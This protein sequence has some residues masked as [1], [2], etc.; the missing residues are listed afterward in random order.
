M[1]IGIIGQGFV[2]NAVYQKFKNFFKVYT[3]DIVA[4]LCNSSYD[5]LINNC[6]IIFICIP[7]PMNKDG[8]CNSELVKE[9]LF[10]LNKK[11]KAIVVN[12]ST[13]PPGTTAKFNDQFENLKIIFNPEFL[14]ERNAIEDFNNQDRIILG[15]PRPATTELKQIYSIVFPNAYVI[16]TGSTHAEMIKYFTNCFLA[17]KVSF[18]NEM[19]E[20]C[21]ALDLDYDKVVE[22]ATL[23]TRLGN[24]HW[25]VPGPDGDFGFGGHCFPKD[26]SAIIK[27]TND[28][29]TTNNILKSVQKTNNKVRNNRDWEK[30]KGRAVN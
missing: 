30:M 23:D 18:S 14:T 24:S 9:V 11:S 1:N 21:D 25:A 6:K 5:E 19:H 27:M 8:S 16:K 15:G 17:N 3:Y 12:K 13:I 29:G 28:L 22:Y 4:K 7:T 26:L 20:L 2:G 10:K